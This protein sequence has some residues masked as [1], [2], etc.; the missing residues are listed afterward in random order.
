MTKGQVKTSTVI[1]LP[2][3]SLEFATRPMLP[4]MLLTISLEAPSAFLCR[5]V[6]APSK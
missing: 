6:S 1:F 2:F 4:D 3:V 5:A